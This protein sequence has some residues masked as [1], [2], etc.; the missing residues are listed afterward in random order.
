MR[1]MYQREWFGIG[2]SSFTTPSTRA[3]AAPDF[4]ERFY[5]AFF[6]RYQSWQDLDPIWR[7][8][9]R[10]IAQFIFE[11]VKF[12]DA[13]LSIG[14]GLGWIEHCLLEMNG[15]TIRLEATEVAP[16]SLRW[17]EK[18]IPSERLHLGPFPQCLPPDSRYDLLYLSALDYSL[19]HPSLIS[20]LQQVGQRLVP[21]GQCLLISASFIPARPLKERLITM[22]KLGL[23]TLAAGLGLYHRGQF[24]GWSRTKEEYHQAFLLAGLVDR[25]DGFI[26]VATGSPIYWVSGRRG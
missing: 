26:P 7:D 25:R 22:V 8:Q 18:E 5:E 24:W 13:V 20:L 10:S 11:Q 2:F 15:L 1:K 3:L 21:G 12:G 14:C 19:D 6:K 17:I 23:A 9:K 4:Y 16:S